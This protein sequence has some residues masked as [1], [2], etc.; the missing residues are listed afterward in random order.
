MKPAPSELAGRDRAELRLHLA[1][2]WKM[3]AGNVVAMPAMGCAMLWSAGLT[4]DTAAIAGMAACSLLLVIGAAAWRMALAVLD[5]DTGLA[6]RLTAACARAQLPSLAVLVAAAALA[7]LSLRNQGWQP[8]F[9]A[10]AGFTMLGWLEYVNYYHFQLQNFDSNIDLK[11][12]KAGRG[13]RRAHL[14]RAV[15]AWRVTRR[16]KG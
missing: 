7:A 9:F 14:G 3:E 16:R 15:R 10:A 6:E 1:S 12:L 2:Y 11:R 8:N 5:G 4:P 13:L